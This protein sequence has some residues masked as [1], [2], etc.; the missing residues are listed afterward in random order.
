M[1][2]SITAEEAGSVLRYLILHPVDYALVLILARLAGDDPKAYPPAPTEEGRLARIY[3][4]ASLF[5][6]CPRCYFPMITLPDERRRDWPSLDA[7]RCNMITAPAQAAPG[8]V[9][10]VAAL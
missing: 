3:L 10:T 9:R 2:P 5:G 7:H 6:L 1:S 8:R 4:G